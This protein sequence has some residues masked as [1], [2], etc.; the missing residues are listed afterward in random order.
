MSK[1]TGNAVTMRELV[2]E[3]GL[4]AVRYFFVK[5][6][7]ILIWTLIL[8]LQYHNLMKTLCT[9]HNM[10]M[11]V[12]HLFYVQQMNKAFFATTEHLNLLTAEKEIDLL[13]RLVISRKW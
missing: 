7:A 10:R 6:L 4:D 9:M 13:K 1:R 8:T 11:H 2:E 3:V 12:F 5:Q